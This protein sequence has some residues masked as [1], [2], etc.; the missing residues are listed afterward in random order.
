MGRIYKHPTV[1]SAQVRWQL[2]LSKHLLKF[3]FQFTDL[4]KVPLEL[5][6]ESVNLGFPSH[7]RVTSSED[8]GSVYSR[9]NMKKKKTAFSL[10]PPPALGVA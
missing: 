6:D 8:V 4:S 10:A 5:R 7:Q 9:E 1:K 2:T 3:T